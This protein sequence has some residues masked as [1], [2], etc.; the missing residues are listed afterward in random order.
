M[1][2][3]VSCLLG[4][5]LMASLSA[6][7]SQSDLPALTPKGEA[8]V[9]PAGNPVRFWGVNLVG[10]YPAHAVSDALAANLASLGVNLARP[11]H[12]LRPSLD[13][14]PQMLSG[15]LLKY[16]DNS[17]DFDPL[18]LDRF[19]YLNAALRKNKIYL[20]LS[21]NWTRRYRA[22]DV[23]IVPGDEKDAEAWKAASTSRVVRV[24]SG[25]IIRV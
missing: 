2:F 22:G 16:Q 9:D 8:F 12:N 24:R 17:R 19:D 4:A 1:K 18:A 6:E 21:V 3:I 5:A 15:S 23:E 7:T 14:N 20:A 10:L 11:H 25:L 13:W